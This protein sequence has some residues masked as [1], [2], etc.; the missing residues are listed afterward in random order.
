MPL[1][2]VFLKPLIRTRP[3]SI[4]LIFCFYPPC[5]AQGL[6]PDQER[7][8]SRKA[9]R[10]PPLDTGGRCQRGGWGQ[11]FCSGGGVKN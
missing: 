4:T 2:I 1:K 10:G 7:D 5:V 8:H 11:N 6:K 3:E 9:Y